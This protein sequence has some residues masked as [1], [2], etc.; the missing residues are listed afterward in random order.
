MTERT[1]DPQS[2]KRLRSRPLAKARGPCS[3]SWSGPPC[4][5]DS[6]RS[7]GCPARCVWTQGATPVLSREWLCPAFEGVLLV[8]APLLPGPLPFSLATALCAHGPTSSVD[9]SRPPSPHILHLLCAICGRTDLSVPWAGGA[10]DTA[11][12]NTG[13]AFGVGRPW[14]R[15]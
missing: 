7:S 9:S 5:E 6:G 13:L 14:R 1:Y 3:A 4:V 15:I 10:G 8:L 11:C 2:L 12:M